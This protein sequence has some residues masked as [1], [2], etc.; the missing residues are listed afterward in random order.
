MGREGQALK[1]TLGTALTVRLNPLWSRLLLASQKMS[2]I[3]ALVCPSTQLGHYS[4]DRQPLTSGPA[5]PLFLLSFPVFFLG[6]GPEWYG[7]L[8]RKKGGPK[9][10]MCPSHTLYIPLPSSFLYNMGWVCSQASLRDGSLWRSRETG[11]GGPSPRGMRC[12]GAGCV[13]ICP[14]SL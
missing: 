11:A 14:F 10:A 5:F 12:K 4:K 7:V 6:G 8:G 13:N 9:G 1:R 2:S 3:C